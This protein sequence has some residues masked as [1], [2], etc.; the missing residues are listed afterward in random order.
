M[1]TTIRDAAF[2][3]SPDWLRGYWGQRFV[4]VTLGLVGDLVSHVSTIAIRFGWVRDSACE[5][6]AL[7]YHGLDR[8]MPRYQVETD[9]EYQAR[10]ANAWTRWQYAGTISGLVAELTAAGYPTATV[11]TAAT[12]D[13]GDPDWSRYQ[14][15]I[16]AADHSVT[17][18]SGWVWDGA[19]IWDTGWRW[20][21]ADP[22]GDV[23]TVCDIID[24]LNPVRWRCVSVEFDPI[25]VPFE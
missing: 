7:A 14:V 10:L 22:D 2:G 15:Y 20:D 24:T 12:F 5:G 11:T 9:A 4:G 18:G 13:P 3:S 8:A 19:M 6:T 25:V 1:P 17:S 23:A 21:V 16:G